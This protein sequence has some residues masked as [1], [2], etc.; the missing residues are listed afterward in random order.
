MIFFLFAVIF[1]L[2]ITNPFKYTQREKKRFTIHRKQKN[3][4]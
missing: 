1:L 4:H 2:L 3:K